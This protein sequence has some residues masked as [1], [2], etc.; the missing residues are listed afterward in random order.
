MVKHFKQ[1][2]EYYPVMGRPTRLDTA[3]LE[4]LSAIVTDYATATAALS[5]AAFAK[6]VHAEEKQVAKRRGK[7]LVTSSI[8]IGYA[9]RLVKRYLK[10]RKDSSNQTYRR[11]EAGADVRNF[12]SCICGLKSVLFEDPMDDHSKHI[13]AHL[14][15]NMDATGLTLKTGGCD[16]GAKVITSEKAERKMKK[17]HRS[18]AAIDDESM[19]KVYV[20]SYFVTTASGQLLVSAYLIKDESVEGD[21][22]KSFEAQGLNNTGSGAQGGRGHVFVMNAKFNEKKWVKH[23]IVDIVRPAMLAN[24]ISDG[25]QDNEKQ[26]CLLTLDGGMPQVQAFFD[27]ATHKLFEND[28]ISTLKYP[29]SC[30]GF[31]QSNDPSRAFPLAKRFC[32][33]MLNLTYAAVEGRSFDVPAYYPALEEWLCDSNLTPFKLRA[34][35]QLILDFFKHLPTIL[36]SSFTVKVVKKGYEVG[37]INPWNPQQILEQCTSWDEMSEAEVEAVL[38]AVEPLTQEFMTSDWTTEK[39]MDELKVPVLKDEKIQWLDEAAYKAK[40]MHRNE[41]QLNELIENRQRAMLLTGAAALQR[42]TEKLEAIKQH[43]LQKKAA[44]NAKKAELKAKKAEAIAKKVELEAKK[45]AAA[46]AA[47]EKER[48]K[49]DKL[50]AQAEKKRANNQGK[51]QQAKPKGA[52]HTHKKGGSAAVQLQ[53]LICFRDYDQFTKLQQMKWQECPGCHFQACH[54]HEASLQQHMLFCKKLKH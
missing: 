6:L 52:S 48:V 43:E 50:K 11:A 2:G 46:A 32:N 16:F 54:D 8:D 38:D 5:G 21:G 15:C 23:F 3:A 30:S 20:P 17:Q 39:K 45:V 36:Q 25:Q 19:T 28:A 31:L 53:C 33:K 27:A 26:R 35:K 18:T 10:T 13:P 7:R 1:T 49:A 4:R 41:K 42:R 12:L 34:K 51:P 37:G 22:W 14:I 24:R 44:A 29:A 47:V 9:R 40:K